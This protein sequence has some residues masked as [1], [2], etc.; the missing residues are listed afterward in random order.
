MNAATDTLN[1][2][3]CAHHWVLGQ[4]KAGAIQA[5]CRKCGGERVY[6]AV[7]DDLDP[8]PDAEPRQRTGVATAVG[9]ARPSSVAAPPADAESSPVKRLRLV[10]QS[11]RLVGQSKI[12]I[13]G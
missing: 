12:V 3:S 4:P 8:R 11:R 1:T 7:L 6:P 13:K 5:T 2:T 10:G 9:G